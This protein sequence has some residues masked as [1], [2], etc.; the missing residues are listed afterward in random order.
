M[1]QKLYNLLEDNCIEVLTLVHITKM[2]RRL[3]AVVGSGTGSTRGTYRVMGIG[4]VSVVTLIPTRSLAAPTD[5][6]SAISIQK[7]N[8]KQCHS[9]DGSLEL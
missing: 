1:V 2:Y 8:R 4:T 6:T 5:S 3:V 7:T 9:K